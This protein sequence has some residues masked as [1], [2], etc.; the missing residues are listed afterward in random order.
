VYGVSRLTVYR[1]L[2]RFETDGI[3]GLERRPASGHPRKLG[4]LI[5]EAELKAV[6]FHGASEFGF[7]SDLSTVGRLHRVI[8]EEYRIN[9]SDNT[10]WRR[11]REAGLTHQKPERE[12]YGIDEVAPEAWL[13]NDVPEIHETVKKHRAILYFSGRIECLADGLP[14]EDM[15]SVRSR[16][17]S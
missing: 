3:A 16:E 2:E 4:E 6:V 9:L 10:V 13:T 15:G 12:Y 14:G 17:P 5:I 11:L 8:R 1:W 7:E